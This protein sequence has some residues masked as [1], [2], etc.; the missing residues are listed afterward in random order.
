MRSA[1]PASALYSFILFA[2]S[3]L[4]FAPAALAEDPA[5]EMEE[6]HEVER[7]VLHGVEEAFLWGEH[8]LGLTH[9]FR[10]RL[11]RSEDFWSILGEPEVLGP[12]DGVLPFSIESVAGKYD[13][14][15]VYNEEVAEY[16]AFF[17][18][19]GRRF[20]TKWLERERRYGPLFREILRAYELPEDLVYLAMI[21]SGFSTQ[22]TSRAQAV[23]PWQF[24]ETTGRRYGL[25]VDFWVDERRDPIKSTHAAARFLR[26]LHQ[27]YG[28]WYLAWASYNAGPARVARAIR[29]HE[30]T[31]F[32]E[33]ART[34][35][36]LRE[37]TR[38]YVPK[39]IA[40]ALIAK[41]P[42]RFGFH[43]IA[44]LE[45]L[46]WEEVEVPDATDLD[47]IARLTRVDVSRIREL[48]PEL[49]QWATPPVLG[50]D[51]PYRLRLPRGTRE[52]FL[53][54]YAKIPPSKRFTF[55][56]YQVQKGDTLS[57]I[58]RMFRTTAAEL[59]R[60]NRIQDP[61]RLRIGQMLMIPIPPGT[62][63]PAGARPPSGT[64]VASRDTRPSAT[65]HVLAEGETLSDVAVRHGISVD[66]L[67]R[68][69]R[70]EDPRRVRAGT[71]LRLR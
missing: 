66:E 42:E 27:Q 28:D 63:L 22:A 6:L 13:I 55:R 70:I 64:A 47:L 49:C 12:L 34:P 1:A 36:A 59:I 62:P 71:R 9:P 19:P 43:E 46:D 67:M 7:R 3:C 33:L 25:R 8:R 31:D 52:V 17:Q 44:S 48:N 2:A 40:A 38:N 21:E 54:E 16:L 4:L 51:P 18:G 61:R 50:K 24:I 14:P 23:G 26:D 45:R 39:L 58:A 41:H 35:G 32:W 69:N 5:N 11:D 30:T 68:L 56:S 10:G 29:D 65:H 37:E 20:F 53:A 15:I 57:H 60:A